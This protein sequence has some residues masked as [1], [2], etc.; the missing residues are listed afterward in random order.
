MIY[1][2]VS[3]VAAALKHAT[4]GVNAQIA[5]LTTAGA[6]GT[7]APPPPVSILTVFD[8]HAV[9][10]GDTP[11][12]P[13]LSVVCAG[14]EELQPYGPFGG[15]RDGVVLI[16]VRYDATASDATVLQLRAAQTI[17]AALR[18]IEWL[19]KDDSAPRLLN[20]VQWNQ[21]DQIRILEV[22][23]SQQSN[24]ITLALLLKVQ[25]RDALP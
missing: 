11:D 18:T 20:G 22:E 2:A 23:T 12:T 19:C 13:A 24:P 16:A 5:A 9:A 1:E 7:T 25:M 4:R 21:G 17:R 14:V 3:I 8:D 15:G 6:W 10:I